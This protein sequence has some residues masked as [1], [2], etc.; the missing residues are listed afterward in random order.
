MPLFILKFIKIHLT[1]HL[2]YFGLS[3]LEIL[4]KQLLLPELLYCMGTKI[5]YF[6]HYYVYLSITMSAKDTPV[7][8]NFEWVLL[9][10]TC[11]E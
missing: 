7:V 6:E 5:G 4:Y 1:Q 8:L 10:K 2:N 11:E 3:D 9:R